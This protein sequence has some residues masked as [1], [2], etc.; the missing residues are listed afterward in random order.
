MEGS[1]KKLS[2]DDRAKQKA[3][4]K[5]YMSSKVAIGGHFALVLFLPFLLMDELSLKINLL[6]FISHTVILAG[7][8][9]LVFRYIKI[10]DSIVET[11]SIDHWLNLYRFGTFMTGLAWGMTF[12]FL[13]DLPIEYHF[14]VYALIVGAAA[15]GL[16]TLGVVLSIYVSF[17]LPMF[18]I[19]IIWMFLQNDTIHI[20]TGILTIL[21][22]AYY[23]YSA[24]QFSHN[25]KQVFVE[26]ER[27]KEYVI[28]LKNEYDTFETL[29]E[30]S[31]DGVLIV[32]NGMFVQCNEKIIEMLHYHSK[33]EVLNTHPSKLSPKFQPDGRESYEKAEEMMALARKNGFHNFEW[34]HTRA[35]NKDFWVDVTLTPINLHNH[36]VIHVIW[37]DISDKKKAEQKL[38]E[39]K[40]ILDYQAHHDSLTKLPNRILFNDRL[41]QGI[42]KAKRK[43]MNLV[44]LFIDLDH[45]KQIN[46][47]LGHGTGDK[48]LKMVTHR[49]KNNIRKGDTLARLGGDEF[50][51]IMEDIV[52]VQGASL[53]AQK[54]LK[55]LTE[56][57]HIDDHIFYI[58]GSIGISLYP[59]DGENVDDLLKYAD[60]AMYRAK[61]EGRNNFQ[62][63]SSDMTELAL[64]RV[65]MVTSLRQGIKNDEFVVYYQPQ[66]DASIGKI[67]GV[68][69]LVRWRHPTMG[70]LSPIKFIALA[71]ETG[72]IKEI[73]E[74]VMHQAMQ[75][76][77]TWYK[78]G[79]EPGRLA[80]NLTMKQLECDNFIQVLHHNMQ[81]IDFK[82]EWLELEV[83]EGQVMKK[84]EEAIVRLNQIAELGIGI[85][86]DDFGTGYS[87]LSYL[88][89][90][91]INKLKIDQSFVRDIP[92]DDEDVAIVKAIIALAQSL[93][94]D[95][96]AEGV[97]TRIQKEFLL[98]NGCKNIQGYYYA[99]PMPSDEMKRYIQ[100]GIIC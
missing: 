40:D 37:R 22:I 38:I 74:L 10:R 4:D 27:S 50:T 58:S 1:I 83:T 60:T 80:L 9:Y 39:Q 44:L 90:F 92:D 63:Y 72:L 56:P 21:G 87:S 28:E 71:E 91:P 96:L 89:R 93:D 75:Q 54:I 78:E 20:V 11:D 36:D 35:N 45:F 94:L 47:S 98:F 43:E 15:A 33:D 88:K 84:P 61:D 8:A 29:F 81:S 3:V 59:Q 76:I 53:L 64:E 70:L 23:Y 48:F 73:D 14:I 46:D 95:L 65:S 6:I 42:E 30:K 13:T 2:L 68:E 12:F 55:I 19:C 99:K 85:A 32:E 52:N 100:K 97:E 18:G 86:I 31:P 26:K 17:I 34:V 67:M 41:E 57:F 24:H 77:R 82:P 51:I 16:L 7:R 49:L 62:F 69:A 79:L 66:V 25:F 5:I